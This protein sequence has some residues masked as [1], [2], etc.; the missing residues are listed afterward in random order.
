[1]F[2]IK[3]LFKVKDSLNS[4]PVSPKL[5]GKNLRV[6]CQKFRLH[7]YFFSFFILLDAD[8]LLKIIFRRRNFPYVQNL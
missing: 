1:M 4:V 7:Y 2:R 6:S 3:Y 5:S 8:E